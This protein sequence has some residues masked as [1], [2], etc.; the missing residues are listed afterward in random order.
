MSPKAHTLA[1]AVGICIILRSVLPT[2][3]RADVEATIDRIY[4]AATLYEDKSN[5]TI[6]K[7]A[8][9]G[10]FQLDAYNVDA[11][12][13]ND[14]GWDMR[15]WRMGFKGG[16]FQ[17]FDFKIVGD[18]NDDPDDFY[19]RLTDCYLGWKSASGVVLKVGKQS[20]AFTLD[21]HT[22]SNDLYTTERS[23]IGNN[24]WFPEEYMTGISLDGE[25]DNWRTVAGVYSAGSENGEFGHFDGSWF[26]LLSLAYEFSRVQSLD[27]GTVILDF[28]YQAPD[29]DNTFT[30]PNEY[31]GSLSLILKRGRWGLQGNISGTRG[32]GSQGN[33]FGYLIM[34]LFD[35]T[36]KLQAAVQYSTLDSSDPQGI[37]LGRYADRVVTG[38]G[39]D[40]RQFYA[41]LNYYVDG[42]RLKLQLGLDWT[43]MEDSTDSGGDYRGLGV[44]LAL[45]THW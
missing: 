21:G 37:R 9:T 38:R 10:R 29:I 1:T 2:A 7:F 13:G 26:A 5:P 24:V 14:N 28:V 23:T 16:M 19:K 44:T 11:D 33:L 27:E 3:A 17:N 8:F 22:S 43:R 18:F 15:R 36:D 42:H 6:Q 12:Q 40:Y 34:P 41:G 45:R 25:H 20:V 4:G 35:I 31:V 30:R 39:D 32:Y